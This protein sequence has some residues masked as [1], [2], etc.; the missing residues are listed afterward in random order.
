MAKIVGGVTTTP[1][2]VSAIKENITDQKYNP[3]SEY[4]QSGKAVAE[5]LSGYYTN[6]EIDNKIGNLETLLGGI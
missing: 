2:A 3:E 6:D 4:A 5:A 1:M